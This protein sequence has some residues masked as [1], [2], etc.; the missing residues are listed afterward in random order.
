MCVCVCVYVPI[1]IHTTLSIS[2]IGKRL[3]H[4]INLLCFLGQP[5]RGQKHPQGPHQILIFEVEGVDEG[6]ED[7]LVERLGV[8]DVGLLLC[9]CVYVFVSVKHNLP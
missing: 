8:C 3:Q 9:V 4:P 5:E 7:L 6:L 2:H 1:Y